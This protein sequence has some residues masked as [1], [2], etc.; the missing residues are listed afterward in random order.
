MGSTTALWQKNIPIYKKNQASLDGVPLGNRATTKVLTD[1]IEQDMVEYVKKAAAIFYGITFD[2]TCLFF[3][4][5]EQHMLSHLTG[6]KKRRQ[7][8]TGQ[9][10][11]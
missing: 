4:S 5:G 8:L 6:L 2:S 9:N 3:R 11:F 1:A 7:V 10:I